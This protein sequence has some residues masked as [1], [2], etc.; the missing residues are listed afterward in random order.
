MVQE[1]LHIISV[2]AKSHNTMYGIANLED[3]TDVTL[4]GVIVHDTN[5]H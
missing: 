3:T 2:H 1:D 5:P 4:S